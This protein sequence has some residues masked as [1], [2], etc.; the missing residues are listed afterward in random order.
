MATGGEATSRSDHLTTTRRFNIYIYDYCYKR[1]FHKTASALMGEA[2]I[3]ADSQ[4]PI[5]ANQGLLFEWWTVFWVLFQAK[6]SGTGS[7]DAMIYTQHQV[8]RQQQVRMAS[9]PPIA[10]MTNGIPRP[11]PHMNGQIPNGIPNGGPPGPGGMQNATPGAPFPGG[12]QLNGISGA[13][14]AP[15]GPGGQN[16]PPNMQQM[17]Q[18]PVGSQQRAPKGIPSYRSPTMAHSPQNPATAGQQPNAAP[19]MS[20]MGPSQPLTQMNSRGNMFAPNGN[21]LGRSPSQPGSPAQNGLHP[22]PSPSMA[23]RQ[24]PGM[25]SGD[26]RH[27]ESQILNDLFRMPQDVL[28]RIR[29]EAGISSDKELLSMTPEERSR[30]FNLVRTRGLRPGQQGPPAMNNA[31]AGPSSS[32]PGQHGQQRNQQTAPNQQVGPQQRPQPPAQAQQQTQLHAQQQAQHAQQQAQ[33]QQAQQ[34]QQ[35]V[36]KRSS[37]SPEQEVGC[38]RFYQVQYKADRNTAGAVATE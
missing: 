11:G 4:P 13:P 26:I 6:S 5:N 36:I 21:T 34:Q 37:T 23:A 29:Q 20:Q 30:V 3:P 17:L 2:D 28:Q 9:Q 33:Q 35:R 16:Q 8:Q 32:T 19:G 38:F 27:M 7:D 24:P 15:G 12:P 18:R 14:G 22:S 1:G 31:A 10:R 25:Y